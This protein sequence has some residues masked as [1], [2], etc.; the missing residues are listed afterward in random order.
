MRYGNKTFAERAPQA[1]PANAR[2]SYTTPMGSLSDAQKVLLKLAAGDIR[3]NPG[4]LGFPDLV[5][6][7]Q[8]L[9]KEIERRESQGKVE[10]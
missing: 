1:R 3:R 8:E 6:L 2:R 9:T 7:Q 10:A 5:R 4:A